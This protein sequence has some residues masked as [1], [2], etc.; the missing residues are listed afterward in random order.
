MAIRFHLDE[1]VSNAI[2]EALRRRAIDVTTTA[3]AGLL[4]AS[5]LEHLEFARRQQRVIFSHDTDFLI[6]AASGEEHWGIVHCE[7]GSRSIGQIVE[8]L[9]LIHACF[10][11]EEMRNRVEFI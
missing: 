5:D 4:G 6:H 3:D 2:A 8:M 9:R 10:S 7:S 1:H 11:E